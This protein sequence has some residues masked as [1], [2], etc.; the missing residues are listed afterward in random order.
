[1]SEQE[2]A[3]KKAMLSGLGFNIDEL[4]SDVFAEVV[5]Y[6]TGDICGHIDD[7]MRLTVKQLADKLVDV[8]IAHKQ[9]NIDISKLY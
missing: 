4:L 6:S 8:S 9:D 1:M 5:Y 3:I 7:P 2:L